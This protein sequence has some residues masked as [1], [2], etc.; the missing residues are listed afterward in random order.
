MM[1][2]YKI[3]VWNALE[4]VESITARKVRC[5]PIPEVKILHPEF[6]I[7]YPNSM[8]D[9]GYVGMSQSRDY[10]SCR[11]RGRLEIGE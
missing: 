11:R 5:E 1:F 8:I 6:R 3:Y 7:L 10:K 4:I 2:C 9:L